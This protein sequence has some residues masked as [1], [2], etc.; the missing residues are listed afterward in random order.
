MDDNNKECPSSVEEAMG[1]ATFFQA[2]GYANACRAILKMVTDGD[3]D[4]GPKAS[5]N[6]AAQ[7]AKAQGEASQMAEL[8]TR[9]ID[10]WDSTGE[11]SKETLHTLEDI[12]G[13]T[14]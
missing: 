8:G 12:L 6:I 14:Q 3:L 11:K 9:F 2:F 1:I 4:L 13:D 5:G 7:L 10:L